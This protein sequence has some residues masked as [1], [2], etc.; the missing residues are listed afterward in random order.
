V[1]A[2]ALGSEPAAEWVPLSAL[3]MWEQNPRRN[4]HAV[5]Q[6]AA[7]ISRFGFAAP[8]VARRANG[9][10]VGGHTRFKAA[11]SLGLTQVPVRFVDLSEKEARLLALADN[12]LGEIAEW[13]NASLH[14]ALETLTSDEAQL[15]G[16][17]HDETAEIA[18]AALGLNEL[19]NP[20]LPVLGGTLASRFLIAPF[21]VLNARE[22]WWQE[23][24]R[25]WIAIGIKSE[26]GRVRSY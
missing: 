6:V 9:E 11:Q 4:D 17:T 26:L 2:R 18:R 8:I 24:K 13:D 14:A 7:S 21:S 12:R 25:A 5:A 20:A 22:G 1:T 10:I 23:R 19:M 3:R 16:W 15:V